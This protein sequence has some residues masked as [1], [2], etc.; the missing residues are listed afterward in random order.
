MAQTQTGTVAG[1]FDSESKAEK[2]VRELIDAGFSKNQ[3]GL[4]AS[5]GTGSA[6][7]SA[8]T[9]GDQV[10]GSVHH[11][12]ESFWNRMKDFFTGNEAEPYAGEQDPGSSDTRE[13]TDD[14][15]DS[16]GYT[17]EVHHSLSGLAVPTDRAGY[18]GNRLGSGRGAV[19]TVSAND[20]VAEAESIL[21]RNGADLGNDTSNV[22]Q[23]FAANTTSGNVDMSDQQNIKLYGEVLRVHKDRIS[24]GEV[25]LR[26][27]TITDTQ[28]IQ[29]PVT[30]EELV[31]ERVP[32]SGEVTE[33][34]ADAFSGQEV[35]IPLTEER[36]SVDK[37]AVLQEQVRV[38]K[39]E[40]GSTESFDETVRREQLKVDDETKS[41]DPTRKNDKY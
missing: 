24:R 15:Y 37:Q 31:I 7:G 30:R 29:V 2:A 35:R 41:V 25:R 27:E 38:G 22:P 19:V 3:I 26:K 14:G 32:V 20:R 12:G 10:T 8:Y 5:S 9:T 39:R 6:T 18:F 4:A 13:I 16:T 28:T 21:E 23:N 36:A 17:D 40:V 33:A 1:F 11:E 34:G